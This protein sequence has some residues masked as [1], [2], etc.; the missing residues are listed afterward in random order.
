M[1]QV[2]CL[3]FWVTPPPPPEKFDLIV[4]VQPR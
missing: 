1:V 3:F 2:S 4:T